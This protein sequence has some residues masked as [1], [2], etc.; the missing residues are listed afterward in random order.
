MATE[1]DFARQDHGAP[2][3][4]LA[5]S[6]IYHVHADATYDVRRQDPDQLRLVAVYTVA[7]Q[8]ALQLKNRQLTLPPDTL[9]IVRSCDI[10][11]YC[12]DR[13]QPNKQPQ[14]HFWWFEFHNLSETSPPIAA[15]PTP[16]WPLDGVIDL[17]HKPNISLCEQALSALQ[18]SSACLASSLVGGQL[19]IWLYSWHVKQQANQSALFL[20]AVR[21]LKEDCCRLTLPAIADQQVISVRTLR[22]LFIRHAGCSPGQY[23]QS[24]RMTMAAEWLRLTSRSIS[25]IADQLGFS[26]VAIFSRAFHQHYGISPR[27]YRNGPSNYGRTP[28]I[29]V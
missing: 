5:V 23:R 6:V 25:D 22:N 12:A 7:G 27:A 13:Q 14:W 2:S 1:F 11:H 10:R 16:L 26:S 4:A 9:V 8:G 19:A 24:W 18:N 20:Q 29:R 21:L 3:L 17:K 15:Q 28:K